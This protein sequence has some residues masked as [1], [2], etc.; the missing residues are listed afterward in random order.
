MPG[1]TNSKAL[2]VTKLAMKLKEDMNVIE[3]QKQAI[4]NKWKAAQ[5]EM[6]VKDK[7]LTNITNQYDDLNGEFSELNDYFSVIAAENDQLTSLIDDFNKRFDELEKEIGGLRNIEN[8]KN[9]L[10]GVRLQRRINEVHKKELARNKAELNKYKAEVLADKKASQAELKAV[11]AE[12]DKANKEYKLAKEEFA[13]YLKDTKVYAYVFE[14]IIFPKFKNGFDVLSDEHADNVN[15]IKFSN[16]VK[17]AKKI[18]EKYNKAQVKYEKS[19]ARGKSAKAPVFADNAY[20]KIMSDIVEEFNL[21]TSRLAKTEV[22]KEILDNFLKEYPSSATSED[23][24]EQIVSDK[25]KWNANS[26]VKSPKVYVPM[27]AAAAVI[28]AGIVGVSYL[29][30]ALANKTYEADTANQIT[31]ISSTLADDSVKTHYDNILTDN[32]HADTVTTIFGENKTQSFGIDRDV[33]Y[34]DLAT[35][36][37]IVEE[38]RNNAETIIN[39]DANGRIDSSCKY[40]VAVS[41]YNA[42]VQSSNVSDAKLYADE[43]LSYSDEMQTYSSSST[44]GLSTMLDAAGTSMDEIRYVLDLL[45]NP[46]FSV[47]FSSTDVAR[48]GNLLKN[49]AKGGKT[50]GVISNVYNRETGDVTILAECE[51]KTHTT[52]Y[53]LVSFQ[54]KEGLINVTPETLMSGLENGSVVASKISYDKELLTSVEGQHT[55]MNASNGETVSGLPT[56]AYTASAKYDDK[57]GVTKITASALLVV[58]DEAGNVI[59]TN[60]VSFTKSYQ[61]KVTAADKENEIKASLAR[62]LNKIVDAE[63]SLNV[64]ADNELA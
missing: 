32:S 47:E 15:Q 48:F 38:A 7:L 27:L 6:L 51:D 57:I 64:E 18:D 61:G 30:P 9:N 8:F 34:S 42:A 31:Q 16:A 62:E 55:Q 26:F 50:L 63:V 17:A 44:Q 43:I 41:N 5:S 33:N 45:N 22:T 52:Y 3:Q 21:Y 13:T 35:G 1:I 54:I 58:K 49:P 25:S 29:V 10:E 23:I 14:D 11:Q 40:A 46:S 4:E 2:D 56:V 36:Y 12:L 28:V 37:A 19:I 20:S 24:C 39:Y 59:G 53:N 60:T